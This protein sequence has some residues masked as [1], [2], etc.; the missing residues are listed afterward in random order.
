MAETPC[1]AQARRL[2]A[3]LSTF[4]L[5]AGVGLP[6]HAEDAARPARAAKVAERAFHD[7]GAPGR[8]VSTFVRG[9]ASARQE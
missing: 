2:L 6:A 8:L 4:G 7:A 5:I 3:T 1:L 9:A